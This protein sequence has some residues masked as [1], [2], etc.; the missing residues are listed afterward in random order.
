MSLRLST[1]EVAQLRAALMVLLSPLDFTSVEAWRAAAR[2][3]IAPLV[4]AE[5]TVS[6]LPLPGEQPYQAD[7]TIDTAMYAEHFYAD[8]VTAAYAKA[9]GSHAFTWQS[10]RATYERPDRSAWLRS[11]F[12]NDWVRPQRLC[13]PCGLIAVRS[14]AELP[15]PSLPEYS[16][17]TGLWFYRNR[18]TNMLGVGSRELGILQLLL[19]AYEAGLHVV[20]RAS[21]E[22]RR[23]ESVLDTMSEGAMLLDGR[24]HVVHQNPAMRRFLASSAG[25]RDIEATCLAAGRVTLALATRKGLKSAREEIGAPTE[26]R[27]KTTNGVRHVRATLLGSDT[28]GIGPMALVLL[29]RAAVEPFSAGELHDQY[30]LTDR[31]VVVSRLLARGL[32]NSQIAEVLGVSIHTARRHSERVLSKLG[33]HSRAAVGAKLLTH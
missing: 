5:T 14:P 8:D 23:L 30:H 3:A 28:V 6:F 12:F 15:C 11:E 2:G 31:E 18:D 24:G 17:I 16:G 22:R 27:I 32:K 13:Q 33:V 25:A 21:Q 10:I 4:R 1:K 26:K 19:P 20:V 7:R 29:E 9:S